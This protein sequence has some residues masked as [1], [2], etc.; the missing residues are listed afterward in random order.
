MTDDFIIE[1][2]ETDTAFIQLVKLDPREKNRY[3]VM[4]GRSAARITSARG[5]KT[6]EKAVSVFHSLTKKGEKE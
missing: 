2:C 6:L 4:S 3:A 5:F 1:E